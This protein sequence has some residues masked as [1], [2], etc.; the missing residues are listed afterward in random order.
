ME[1]V[2][3]GYEITL[4]TYDG[5]RITKQ[6]PLLKMLPHYI[7]HDNALYKSFGYDLGDDRALYKQE[8]Y[9][10]GLREGETL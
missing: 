2:T 3:Q 8:L 7:V 10:Y 6:L 4:I 5:N 9:T 1:P